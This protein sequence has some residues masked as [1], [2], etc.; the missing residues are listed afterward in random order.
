MILVKFNGDY[1]KLS[2]DI[3][4]ELCNQYPGDGVDDS[5]RAAGYALTLSLGDPGIACIEVFEAIGDKAEFYSI[6]SVSF[7][8]IVEGYVTESMHALMLFLK[9]FTPMIKDVNELQSEDLS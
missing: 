5:Y 3:D 4:R 9:K 6:I 7:G 8:H 1:E 2:R